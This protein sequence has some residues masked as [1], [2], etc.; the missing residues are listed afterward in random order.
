MEAFALAAEVGAGWI[1]FDVRR[2]ADGVLVC[3]HDAGIQ[4]VLLADLSYAD[5]LIR[6]EEDGYSVPRVEDVFRR[7]R[8]S[9]SMDIEIKEAGYEAELVGLARKY[10]DL[11]GFVMKSFIDDVVA[12]VKEAEPA[13]KAGLLLGLDGSKYNLRK[14][15]PEIFP[16]LRLARVGADFA[17]PHHGL[18]KFGFVPRMRRVG[19]EVWVWTVNDQKVMERLVHLG[20]DAIITDR[21]DLALEVVQRGI[22]GGER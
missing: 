1:E 2:T 10:L 4:G 13:V 22:N 15:A 8:G 16:E 21:P 5:L 19:A 20:V 12:A 9:L 11:D 17:A 3:F 7:F 18:L 6:S 14:R